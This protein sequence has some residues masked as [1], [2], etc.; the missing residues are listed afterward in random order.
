MVR[1]KSASLR[2][3]L[4]LLTVL[5]LTALLT[6]P[7]LAAGEKDSSRATQPSSSATKID[8]LDWP[9]WRGPE[10]NRISRETGLIDSFDPAKKDNILWKNTE[11]GGISSPI[12]LNGKLYTIVRDKPETLEEGEML[13]CIDIASGKTLWKNRWNMF[14]TDVPAE[15]VGWSSCVG[16]PATGR[17]Y[18]QG[19]A[20]FFCCVDGETGKTMWSKS[21]SEEYGILS[22][23]GGRT[24]FPTVFEDLVIVN[25]VMTG[26]GEI[27]RP[28]H[29]FLAMN[30]NTGAVVWIAGTKP[31]PEDTTYSTPTFTVLDGQAAMVIGSADGAVWAF[32]PRTGKD[33]WKYQVSRRG[34][35]VSP[36]VAGDQIVMAQNE[37][38]IDSNDLGCI[39]SINGIGHGDITKTNTEWKFRGPTDG[40][41]SPLI[42]DG[43]VYCADEQCTLYVLDAKKGNLITSVKLLGTQLRATPLF[44]D[45]K[46]YIC[47]TQGWHVLQPTSDGVKFI[48]KKRLTSDNEVTGSLIASHGKIFLPTRSGMYC[49]A[50]PDAKPAAT[51]IPKPRVETPLGKDDPAAWVQV[52]PCDVL[53]KPGEKTPLKVELYNA[54]GQFLREAKTAEVK[55]TIDGPGEVD[56]SNAFVAPAGNK[57][58]ASIVTAKF[59]EFKGQSS[60]RVIPPLPWKFDFE[61]TKLAENPLNK[62]MQGEAPV[63]W[64]GVRYRH[65]V[66]DINGNKV[67]VKVNTIPKGTRSQ[68]WMGS[69]DMHDYTVTADLMGKNDTGSMPD[70]GIIAQRYTLD[71]MNVDDQLQLRSWS[72]QYK[73]AFSKT[74]PFKSKPNIWY[75]IKLRVAVEG[76]TAVLKGKVWPRDEKEPAA[77]TIEATDETA[78]LQG[79]PGLFGNTNNHSEF[80]IDNVTV[81]AN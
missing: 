17:I 26:W 13:I 66:R 60:I 21:L 70:M 1:L 37:V 50:K 58:T 34:M 2:C 55:F 73:T 6:L 72:S 5:E 80:Y 46:L 69:P 65:V 61:E 3:L 24:G 4:S 27:A 11:A 45:G 38:N 44:A 76:K 41:S 78:N 63:T 52:V 71:I 22:T 23:Y 29:R 7:A 8:P 14:L 43:R 42:V 28:A 47:S 40:K 56:S 33:I 75:T 79:S 36:V 39:V 12:V 64:V 49:L 54:R 35:S 20:G 32:Q 16:D 59:G 9:N 77:W 62:K 74:I 15:R 18:A 67:M 30:K 81:T 31:L 68:C 48:D 57:H 25:S 19:T 53:T 10:Q 51:E